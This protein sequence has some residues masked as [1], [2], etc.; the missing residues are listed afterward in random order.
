MHQQLKCEGKA[1]A[2]L[3]VPGRRRIP[4]GRGC[5]ARRTPAPARAARTTTHRKRIVHTFTSRRNKLLNKGAI[6]GAA[7]MCDMCEMKTVRL[8][9][10]MKRVER[11]GSV[12]LSKLLKLVNCVCTSCAVFENLFVHFL[13]ASCELPANVFQNSC[14]L[15]GKF[16]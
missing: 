2:F 5:S 7:E 11:C 4:R 14:E 13:R 3:R 1:R 12:K 10:D 8:V 9:K 6:C 15:L 16:V